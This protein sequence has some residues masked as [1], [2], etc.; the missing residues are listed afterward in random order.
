MKLHGAVS[1]PVCNRTVEPP[2]IS[3]TL[4]QFH[5]NFEITLQR[6]LLGELIAVTA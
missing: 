3:N 2:T 1:L 5:H 6:E 4:A